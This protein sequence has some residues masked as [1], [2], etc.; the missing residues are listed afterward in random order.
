VRE[1]FAKATMQHHFVNMY[2]DLCSVLQ[3]HFADK[4]ISSDPLFFKKILLN[5]CQSSFEEHLT[6]PDWLESLQGEEYDEAV[7]AYKLHMI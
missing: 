6:T 1:I 4:S 2:A 3:A 5:A 7:M